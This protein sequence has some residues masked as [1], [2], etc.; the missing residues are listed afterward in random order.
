MTSHCLGAVNSIM[1]KQLQYVHSEEDTC[2][3]GELFGYGGGFQMN[4]VSLGGEL[5]L[6]PRWCRVYQIRRHR[7]HV[8]LGCNLFFLDV[9]LL[10]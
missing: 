4:V 6:R 8:G 7:P 9:F 5:S 2:V 10:K 1:S 3:L